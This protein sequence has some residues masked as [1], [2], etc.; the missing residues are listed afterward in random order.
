MR[1]N[2]FHF[3]AAAALSVTSLAAQSVDAV[4]VYFPQPVNAGG[5]MLPPGN[6]TISTLKGVGEIPMLRFQSESGGETLAVMVTREYLPADEAAQRSEVI[7]SPTGGSELR[8][9]RIVME[10]SHFQFVVP[11]MDFSN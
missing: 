10:G 7:L 8:I 1:P 9:D 5:R 6:Y 11:L 4:A 2:L 3:A